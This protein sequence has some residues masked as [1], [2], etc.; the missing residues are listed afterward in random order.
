MQFIHLLVVKDDSFRVLFWSDHGTALSGISK[1]PQSD[2]PV[3]AT[4]EDH[5]GVVYDTSGHASYTILLE[6][7]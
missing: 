4:S 3:R 2:G 6:R 7:L 5:G 1:V